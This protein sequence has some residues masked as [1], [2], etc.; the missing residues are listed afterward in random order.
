MKVILNADVENLG[1]EGDICDVKDGYGRNYLLP[2]QLALPYNKSTL[3]LFEQKRDAI[4]KRKEEKRQA[5]LSLKERIEEE[6]LVIR[7]P[8]G[9]TGKLFGS[10]TAATLVEELEKRGIQIERKR[11]ELHQ[12][13]IK[14]VGNYSA[15][16][17]LYNEESAGL[18]FSVESTDSKGGSEPV[19]ATTAAAEPAAAPEPAAETAEV[20]D[21]ALDQAAEEAAAEQAAEEAAEEAAAD[22]AAEE[23]AEVVEKTVTEPV[24]AAETAAEQAT[25][26][27]AVAPEPE[28][29]TESAAEEQAPEEPDT[30]SEEDKTE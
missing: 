1:E 25:G 21:T 16:I 7:R 10:V 5:A 2:K 20:P 30:E 27:D 17:K 29:E 9:E 11:I 15:K 23:A 24:E 4:E 26:E 22:Q 12:H 14:M 6:P 18:K 3:A 28:A 13:N 19:E 8:A